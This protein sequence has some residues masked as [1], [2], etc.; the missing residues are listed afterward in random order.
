MTLELTREKPH[1]EKLEEAVLGAIILDYTALYKVMQILKEEV[2]YCDKHKYIYRACLALNRS[3]SSIDILTVSEWLGANN[4]LSKVGGPYEIVAVTNKIASSANIEY[5]AQLLFEYFVRRKLIHTTEVIQRAA[6]DM[7]QDVMSIL[8]KTRG[9]LFLT[10]TQ[11]ESRVKNLDYHAKNIIDKSIEMQG[12][13]IEIRGVPSG[14][15]TF[16]RSL[17]GFI[18]GRL[19]II[20]GRPSMGKTTFVLN[21]VSNAVKKFGKRV[22]FFSGE[23]SGEEITS[24]IMAKESNR[25]IDEIQKGAVSNWKSILDHF[26]EDLRG[27]LFIDDTPAPSLT[28]LQAETIK[29]KEQ[30]GIDMIVVD[31]LQLMKVNE[32]G[33]KPG[34]IVS[35]ISGALKELARRL[36]IP[37]IALSQLSRTCES[38]TDKRPVMSDL[39][40]SG[41]IEQDADMVAFLYRPEYYG[42]IDKSGRDLTGIA[43]V[44]VRKNRQGPLGK[45]YMFFDKPIGRFYA[46]NPRIEDKIELDAYD[47]T[48][49]KPKAIK[50]ILEKG[51]DHEGEEL[52]F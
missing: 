22:L 50:A 3:G 43:E 44:I 14:F 1:S 52:P 10:T 32:K 39:K 13:Y 31:Y 17:S 51:Y 23:M 19:Y 49:T 45:Y 34:E 12:R 30:E 47:M 35:R 20:G 27:N 11:A 16:D 5:H 6:Y 8:E 4:L 2:F 9:D 29:Q 40:E 24:I 37:V 21:L 25:N 7:G 15:E 38:R 48:L 41:D 26:N 36:D 28:H 42:E 46:Y 33:L 18:G